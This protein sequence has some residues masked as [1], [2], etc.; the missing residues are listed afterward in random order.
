MGDDSLLTA[1]V[2]AADLYVAGRGNDLSMPI[3][4]TIINVYAVLDD[5]TCS[6]PAFDRCVLSGRASRPEGWMYGRV[7]L[8]SRL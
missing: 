4:W 3:L 1:Q 6:L 8:G 5:L 2:Q 7:M